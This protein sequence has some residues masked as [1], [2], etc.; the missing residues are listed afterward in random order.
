M[1]KN[2]YEF[3]A[4]NKEIVK[5][6]VSKPWGKMYV[7]AGPVG[8]TII[9]KDGSITFKYEEVSTETNYQ[10]AVKR[11]KERYPDAFEYQ[12]SNEFKLKFDNYFKEE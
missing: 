3:I 12:M 5:L 9:W 10:N 2:S 7:S 1:D 6:F 8:W 11:L 4:D